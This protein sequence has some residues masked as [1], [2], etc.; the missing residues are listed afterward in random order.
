MQDLALSTIVTASHEVGT[1]E[2]PLGSN[3]G[4][5]VSL[6]LASVHLASAAS[7][8]SA[9]VA[10]C[11]QQAA[12]SLGIVPLMR[13]SASGLHFWDLNPDL[14]FHELTPDSVPCVAVFDHG[15]GLS[16]VVLVCG[17]DEDKGKFSV[18]AGNTNND[19]SRNG[20][21]VFALQ[22]WY[23]ILDPKLKGYLRIA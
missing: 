21:G 2:S 6:Y 11:V 18:I 5:R 16:H 17:Y 1:L 9:F 13:F 8:C 23:S 7:W 15:Q 10:W 12:K 4:P 19:G 22:D 3:W 20:I 14:Q